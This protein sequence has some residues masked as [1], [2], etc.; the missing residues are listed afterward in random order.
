[1][2]KKKRTYAAAAVFAAALIATGVR[3]TLTVWAED[4][5]ADAIAEETAEQDGAKAFAACVEYS[6]QGWMVSGTFR[7]FTPDTVLVQPMCSL[8]NETWSDCGQEWDLRWLGSQNEEERA[9]L[10]RQRC[11]YDSEEPLKSYLAKERDRFYIRLRVVRADGTACETEPAVIERGE[12]RPVPAEYEVSARFASGVSVREGRPPNLRYFGRYQITV[13][14]SASAEEILAC[15]PAALPVEVQIQNGSEYIGSDVVDCPVRWKP[16]ELPPLAA[17]ES[18]TAADAAERI[19]IPA[20]T[21]LHTQTG[22][23]EL[24]EPAGMDSL[25]IVTDEVRLVLN[26]VADGA[27]PAGALSEEN[28]GLDMAFHLKPTGAVSIRAYTMTEG[29]SRWTELSGLS[30]RDAVDAQPSTAGS[31]YALVLGSGQE[32]YRS[33]RE[34]QEAGEEPTPF[35]VGLRIEGG[36][37]DGGQIVLAWPDTYELPLRLPALGGSG[38]NEGNAG[39][40]DREDSTPGGQRPGLTRSAQAA[41]AVPE[42]GGGAASAGGTQAALPGDG[43]DGS[44]PPQSAASAQPGTALRTPAE[45]QTGGE[46]ARPEDAAGTEDA[47]ASGDGK[48]SVRTDPQEKPVR[49]GSGTGGGTPAAAGMALLLTCAGIAAAKGAPKGKIR[50]TADALRG[51][52]SRGPRR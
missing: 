46:D 1:M 45:A 42:A 51:L 21:V 36:V 20:G 48:G 13:R 17:G 25:G 43:T 41:G 18:V 49:A 50:K 4:S 8:D 52:F 38:G 12:A 35:F 10:Y 40:D 28:Y 7:D 30:L 47:G 33:Y 39:S 3:G 6:P 31:G 2:M 26:V 44:G 22:V 29:G 32:P 16:L 5:P 14:E 19:E 11:L 23:Y 27:Q 34:A 37:Y 24:T 9:A 15:L